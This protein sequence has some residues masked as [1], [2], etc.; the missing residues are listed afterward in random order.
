[1]LIFQDSFGN[2]T[3][4]YLAQGLDEIHLI[5]NPDFNGSVK[6]Y[7][8]EVKPDVVLM[9]NTSNQFNKKQAKEVVY[10]LNCFDIK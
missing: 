7:I 4:T 9:L 10:E 5:Y 8:K 2:Y 1:M 3:S 6:A